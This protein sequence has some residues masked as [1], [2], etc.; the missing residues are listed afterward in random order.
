[1]L[2]KIWTD[3]LWI[4]VNFSITNIMVVSQV[5][6]GFRKWANDKL[7]IGLFYCAMCFSF[8]SGL[9]LSFAWHSPTGF[10]LW[11]AFLGSITSWMIYVYFHPR[12]AEY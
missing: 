12:Q 11:D 4:T 8:W 2:E 10:W 7:K 3:L 1:M 6:N 9:M 5:T